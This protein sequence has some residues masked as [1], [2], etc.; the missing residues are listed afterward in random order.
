MWQV[1]LCSSEVSCHETLYTAFNV[2]S[3]YNAVYSGG[4]ATAVSP[5][6]TPAAL[7]ASPTD[8]DE[9]AAA[10]ASIADLNDIL[11]SLPAFTGQSDS[12]GSQIVC[13]SVIHQ[14]TAE[15]PKLL[16]CAICLR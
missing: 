14:N 11:D 12:I 10:T 15:K 2:S 9:L 6:E 7:V 8:D 13:C 5:I 16:K 4:D 3:C 1:T